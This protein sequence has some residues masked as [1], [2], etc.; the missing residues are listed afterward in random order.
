MSILQEEVR[1]TNVTQHFSEGEAQDVNEVLSSFIPEFG[2]KMRLSERTIRLASY[3]ARI[4][5][6][7]LIAMGSLPHYTFRLTAITCLNVAAKFSEH[8]MNVPLLHQLRSTSQYNL[9]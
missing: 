6:E 3:Y 4:F 1:G 7:Q 2:R 8:D 5:L 9:P